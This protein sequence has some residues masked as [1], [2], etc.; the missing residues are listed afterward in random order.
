MRWEKG[1]WL[2]GSVQGEGHARSKNSGEQGHRVFGELRGTGGSGAPCGREETRRRWPERHSGAC[3]RTSL[4]L[5]F[6]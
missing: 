4:S 2:A 1:S 6:L 3:R 5:V